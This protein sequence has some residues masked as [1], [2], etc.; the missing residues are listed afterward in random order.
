MKLVGL[1]VRVVCSC[2]RF[3]FVFIVNSVGIVSEGFADGR[4]GILGAGGGG[5]I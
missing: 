5:G 4:N 3:G 1:G 2:E